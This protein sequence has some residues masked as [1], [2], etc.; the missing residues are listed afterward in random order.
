MARGVSYVFQVVVFAAGAHAALRTGST[1][2]RSG[3]IAEEDILELN[4]ARIG[5]QQGWIVS[6]HK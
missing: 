5:K 3:F 6:R 1:L 4:H 2:I